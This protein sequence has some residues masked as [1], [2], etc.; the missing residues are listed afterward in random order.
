MIGL[1]GWNVGAFSTPPIVKISSAG[2][3]SSK[4]A[5]LTNEVIPAENRLRSTAGGSKLPDISTFAPSVANLWAIIESYG[6]DAQRMF[7]D[8]GIEL[9]FPIDE[10]LRISYEKIDRIRARA[11]ELSGDESFG[12]RAAAFIH[13]SHA[14]PLGYAWLASRSL[15]IALRRWHRY[16]RLVNRRAQLYREEHDGILTLSFTIDLPSRDAHVRDDAGTAVLTQMMRFNYGPDLELVSVAA[17]REQPA[18]TEPWESLYRCPIEFGA[19]RSA[20]RIRSEDAD[21]ILPSANP[22]LAKINED[23]VVRYLALLDGKDFAGA[24]RYEIVRQ[25]PCGHFGQG[26]VAEA[27]NVTPRTLRRRLKEHE[28]TFNALLNDVRQEMSEKFVREA[29]L[30]MTQIA[31]MLGFSE[32]SSFTRAF[33]SWH[34]QSPTEARKRALDES[35]SE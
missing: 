11:A 30:A 24:V 5:I 32:V 1:P 33:R 34:G 17:T 26:I 25:L 12:V 16:I 13:P 2:F 19:E 10:D 22:N 4:V 28:T 14:G 18:D 21:L 31:F 3:L 8:E 29:N 15:R 20:V 7:L 23:L 9:S 6:L 35:G 27:L